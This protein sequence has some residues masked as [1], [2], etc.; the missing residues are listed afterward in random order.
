MTF[1]LV[2]LSAP[3]NF[4][5]PVRT[6]FSRKSNY[7]FEHIIEINIIILIKKI[8]TKPQKGKGKSM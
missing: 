8:C 1:L 6:I 4:E 2:K 3:R 7:N 5:G